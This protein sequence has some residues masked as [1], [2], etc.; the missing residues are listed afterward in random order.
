[1]FA[2]NTNQHGLLSIIRQSQSQEARGGRII[3]RMPF[4]TSSSVFGDGDGDDAAKDRFGRRSD[5]IWK[6]SV[7][8]DVNWGDMDAYGH[9]NNLIY[10]RWYLTSFH[11]H[12][13]SI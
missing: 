2:R 11:I 12:S 4:S 1:M 5:Q 7:V 13:F 6:S 10:L 3:Q 9:V 8:R